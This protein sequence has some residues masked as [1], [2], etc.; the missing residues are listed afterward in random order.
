MT[1]AVLPLI[2]SSLLLA[3]TDPRSGD[4]ARRA[5]TE[6]NR[7]RQKEFYR[8]RAWPG[9]AIPAGARLAAIRQMERMIAE[10]RKLHS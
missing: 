2:F 6:R 7:Q 8:T 10:E 9:N 5:R 3:Q 4:A 1:R